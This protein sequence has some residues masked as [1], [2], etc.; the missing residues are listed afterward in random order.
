MVNEEHVES[1]FGRLILTRTT[2]SSLEEYNAKRAALIAEDRALRVDH[3]RASNHTATEI[4][5]DAIVRRIRK[6]EAE[7][8]WAEEHDD[9]PHPFPGMEFLTGSVA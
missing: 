9:V 4:Q 3:A 1:A 8:I 5:A 2:M 7:T 6:E